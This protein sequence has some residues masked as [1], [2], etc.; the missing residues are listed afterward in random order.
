MSR[1]AKWDN[2]LSPLPPLMGAVKITQA[3]ASS[4]SF[5]FFPAC[6]ASKNRGKSVF[7]FLRWPFGR[8]SA[9]N[10]LSLFFF[11]S[12]FSFPR[13]QPIACAT[14]LKPFVP[15][16]SLSCTTGHDF[17]TTIRPTLL[18]FPL[19]SSLWCFFFPPSFGRQKE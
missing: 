16:P 8:E 11:S 6:P 12:P 14:A 4:S 1:D 15:F 18:S 7:F 2:G 10:A 9:K 5:P 17:C 19:T 3:Q 13:Q